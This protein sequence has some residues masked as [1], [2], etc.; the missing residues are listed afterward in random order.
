MRMSTEKK[1]NTIKQPSHN[2]E[3]TIQTMIEE[4]KIRTIPVQLGVIEY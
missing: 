4:L 3:K 1:H 2:N